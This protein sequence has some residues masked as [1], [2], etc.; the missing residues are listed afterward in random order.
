[1]ILLWKT[2]H[3]KERPLC[4]N[5]DHFNHVEACCK[6]TDVEKQ[7]KTKARWQQWETLFGTFPQRA[8]PTK[9]SPRFI[10]NINGAEI[11]AIAD[12]GSSVNIIDE[13]SYEKLAKPWLVKVF[14][15]GSSKPL[16]MLGKFMEKVS[17]ETF[18]VTKDKSRLS[19]SWKTSEKLGLCKLLIKYQTSHQKWT[20]TKKWEDIFTCLGKLK[21]CQVK[22]H[23]C[24]PFHVW[25]QLE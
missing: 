5:C 20:L 4:R 10:I 2:A 9:D 12:T 1:M 7:S 24:I 14:S 18:F 3:Q 22:L 19:L 23:R 8:L 6:S 17:E 21:G 16:P 11:N 13:L 25:K 15:Y